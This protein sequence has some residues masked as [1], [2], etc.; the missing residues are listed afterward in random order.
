MFHAQ[1]LL[2]MQT[3]PS[4]P[5]RA[6]PLR[7]AF[8]AASPQHG[9]PSLF[10]APPYDRPVEDEFAWH[11]VKYLDERSGLV[12]QHRAETPAGPVWVDFV[13][14]TLVPVAEGRPPLLRRV[15]FELT[16]EGDDA[17]AVALRDALLVGTGAL[18][19]LY[20]FDSRSLLYRLH[21][22]LA[23]VMAWEPALFSDRGRVNLDRLASEEAL[24]V[25]PRPQDARAIVPAPRADEE[26]VDE[27]DPFALPAAAGEPLV[28]TRFTAAHPGAWAGFFAQARAHFGLDADEAQRAA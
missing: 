28:V 4:T 27:D 24:A 25:R 2:A 11:L 16:A 18:D 21:D 13:V 17:D 9:E 15:G 5:Y 8:E 1:P 14:E 19:A 23:V 10:Y 12:Y 6:L 3:M 22:A 20:R 26:L 7:P